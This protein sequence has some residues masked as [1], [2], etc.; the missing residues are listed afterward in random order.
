MQSSVAV[1]WEM[2]IVLCIISIETGGCDKRQDLIHKC[3]MLLKRDVVPNEMLI[4]AKLMRMG[5][6][7]S[8]FF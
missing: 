1:L 6:S 5:F 7:I 2:C 3:W 8:S 4:K